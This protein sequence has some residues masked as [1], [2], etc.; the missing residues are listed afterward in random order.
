[1]KPQ[2]PWLRVFVEGVVIVG[3]I[4]LA[5]G[6]QAWWEGTLERAEE[7]EYFVA[8]L[9]D[10]DAVIAEAE[11]TIAANASETERSRQRIAT[12]QSFQEM[13][14]SLFLPQQWIYRLRS[15]L[16]SYNDIISS[17]GV[18]KL[19]DLHVRRSLARLRA[20]LDFEAET[21]R[22][23]VESLRGQRA[24]MTGAYGSGAPDLWRVMVRVE[25]E[26]IMWLD[27]HIARKRD[28]I[29]AAEEAR[30]AILAAIEGD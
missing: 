21:M 28:V 14:D 11:R 29:R 5:F 7:Q 10:I 23:A 16:D 27:L 8:F 17:G 12:L 24:V 1:M 25:E 3:S 4:L 30:E 15:N 18:T 6:I 20:E 2:I 13:P 9:G 19:R 22:Y 26:A